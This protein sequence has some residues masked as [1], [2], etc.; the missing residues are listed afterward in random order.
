MRGL[1][2][3]IRRACV[4]PLWLTAAVAAICFAFLGYAL[5]HDIPQAAKLAA[6][7]LSTYALVICVTALI[8]SVPI[9]EA[10]LPQISRKPKYSPVFSGGMIF[11][12]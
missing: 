9:R 7:N 12:K 1:K 10:P 11:V 5:S 6:Y 8:T 2:R 3:W 4:L